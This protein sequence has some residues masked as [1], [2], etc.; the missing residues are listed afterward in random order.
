M[1][2]GQSIYGAWQMFAWEPCWWPSL[3]SPRGSARSLGATR[4]KRSAPC[5][6]I[7]PSSAA[8]TILQKP[9]A[10]IYA[11][12]ILCRAGRNGRSTGRNNPMSI[13]PPR[14]FP[15]R[16][17]S[18]RKPSRISSFTT[19]P[20]PFWMKRSAHFPISRSVFHPALA[21]VKNSIWQAV[22]KYF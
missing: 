3:P 17:P 9:G 20:W 7:A 5:C 14:R 2:P 8:S 22:F 10:N 18:V 12:I 19:P 16:P 21:R 6:V 1:S 13:A 4:A 15:T 11:S